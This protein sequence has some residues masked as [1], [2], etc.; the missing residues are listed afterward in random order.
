MAVQAALQRI[1]DQHGV[2]DRGDIDA[3]AR[4][5]GDVVLGVLRHLEHRRVLEQ[6]L[7]A[8][9][10]LGEGKLRQIGGGLEGQ[11]LGRAVADRNVAGLAR[12]GRQR[13]AAQGGVG[14][15]QGVGLGVEGDDAGGGGPGDPAVEGLQ[16]AHAFIGGGVEGRRVRRA[17]RLGRVG[18]ADHRG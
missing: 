12:R 10:H 17:G 1:G 2:V 11:P 9:D 15:G 14:R 6:G 13:Q 18:R 4:Q 5:D 8:G 7:Q 16:I 3:V